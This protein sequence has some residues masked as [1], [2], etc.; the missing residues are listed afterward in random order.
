MPTSFLPR[1][2]KWVFRVLSVLMAIAAV[3]I[4]ATL[5]INPSL[6]GDTKVGPVNV[7]LFG[8]P[9]VLWLKNATFSAQYLMNH[10]VNVRLNDAAGL[11]EVVKHTGL[12]VALLAVVYFGLLFELLRR[13]FA[14]VQHGLSFTRQ[15]LRLV[16]VIGV[17]LLVFSVVSA[18]AEDWFQ[19]EVFRYLSQHAVLEISGNTLHAPAQGD[20]RMDMGNGFPFGNSLFFTGLMVLALSEVFRQG[21]KLKSENDLTI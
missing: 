1:L 11:F 18:T 20:F 10:S 17:S 15:S 5:L 3:A 7:E 21:L 9:G 19:Y 2:L 13:L 4:V 14:N 8:Q 12:P 6:P 16:Q